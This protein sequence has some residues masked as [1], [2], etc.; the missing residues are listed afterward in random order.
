MLANDY[1]IM[2]FINYL[3]KIIYLSINYQLFRI[4]KTLPNSF[5][6]FTSDEIL[7]QKFPVT[8][9]LYYFLHIENSFLTVDFA[10]L[11]SFLFS[12]QKV[13]DFIFFSF[14]DSFFSLK[15]I[16]FCVM[17]KLLINPSLHSHVDEYV[18]LLMA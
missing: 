17:I 13:E 12:M 1:G 11:L 9:G 16:F 15:I 8:W 14:I 4:W 3:K 10:K 5:A 2:F 6:T 18:T 7:V